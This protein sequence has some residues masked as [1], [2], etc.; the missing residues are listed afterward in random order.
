MLISISFTATLYGVISGVV[1]SFALGFPLKNGVI[2]GAI[3][4]IVTGIIFYKIQKN[5]TKSGNINN[6][7]A[8]TVTSTLMAAIFFI[9]ILIGIVAGILNWLFF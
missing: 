1:W 7:E 5:S 2:Y 9:T 4:G 6:Q 3:I 8:L